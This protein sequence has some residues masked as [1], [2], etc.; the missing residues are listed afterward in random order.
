MRDLAQS[1]LWAASGFG[2]IVNLLFAPSLQ[3]FTPKTSQSHAYEGH[4][5]VGI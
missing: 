5:V 1:A 3:R 4:A 2:I